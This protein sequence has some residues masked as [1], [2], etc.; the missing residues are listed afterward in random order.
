MR[1]LVK[2]LLRASRDPIFT[3]SAMLVSFS[4]TARDKRYISR[5]LRQYRRKLGL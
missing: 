4:Y 5:F 3:G 1:D 2:G